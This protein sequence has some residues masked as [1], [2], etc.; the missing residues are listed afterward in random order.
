MQVN[1][2]YDVRHFSYYRKYTYG[3]VD[4]SDNG[5]KDIDINTGELNY[6]ILI[7]GKYI[8]SLLK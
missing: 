6:G 8:Q 5:R 3:N 7:W 4:S 1:Q 2:L